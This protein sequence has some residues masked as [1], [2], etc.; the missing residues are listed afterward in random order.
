VNRWLWV[1]AG[2]VLGLVV[3]LALRPEILSEAAGFWDDV[4]DG[5]REREEELRTQLGI[6]PEQVHETDAETEKS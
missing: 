2:A 5:M 6:D 4:R 3:T 1:A